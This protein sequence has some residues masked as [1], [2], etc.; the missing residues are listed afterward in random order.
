M[1]SGFLLYLC[2]NVCLGGM[3]GN[4]ALATLCQLCV[5]CRGVC[6]VVS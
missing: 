4:E 6:G 2:M 5:L 3:R 1:V